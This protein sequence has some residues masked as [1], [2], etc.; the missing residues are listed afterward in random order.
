MPSSA[1]RRLLFVLIPL[2]LSAAPA[3]R[4]PAPRPAGLATH[5]GQQPAPTFRVAV[6]HVE[7]TARIVDGQGRFVDDL[8]QDELEILEENKPQSIS[9]F[10]LVDIPVEPAVPRPP[11]LAA[12][13]PDV[14]TNTA[15]SDGR[16]YVLVLDNLNVAPD[17]I[18]EVRRIARRFL[19]KYFADGDVAA[20][21]NTMGTADAS[22]EFTTNRQRLL[23]AVERLAPFVSRLEGLGNLDLVPGGRSALAN[24]TLLSLKTMTERL[25]TVHGRRKAIVYFSEGPRFVADPSGES[26]LSES[27]A[28]LQS[29]REDKL[30][31]D[32]VDETAPLPLGAVRAAYQRL[33]AAAN[34]GNVAIY[35]VDPRGLGGAGISADGVAIES[36]SLN[37]R[38]LSDSTGGFATTDTNQL[39]AGFERIRQ[40]NSRYYVLGYYPSEAGRVGAFRKISVR[41]RRP[42]LRAIARNGYRV[43][44][45]AAASTS[46]N[47][48]ENAVTDALADAMDSLVPVSGLRL[49]ATATAFRG[50]K[51]GGDVIVSMQLDGRDLTL[52]CTE[53]NCR[54]S[55]EMVMGTMNSRAEKG[56]SAHEYVQLPFEDNAR[57][58]VVG[59]GIRLVRTLALAPGRFQLRVGVLDRPT[60]RVG[61][62]HIDVTVPDHDKTRLGMSGVLVT[63]SLAGRVPTTGGGPV[64]QLK[65]ELPGPP[66]LT[67]EFGA[68]ESLTLYAELYGS[69]AS[70]PGVIVATSVLD[71]NGREVYR[72]D[73]PP[74]EGAA[75]A[76]PPAPGK[77]EVR[78][79]VP[80]KELAPGQY[81]LRLEARVPP[82]TEGPV[83]QSVPFRVVQ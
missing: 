74:T 1:F 50:A 2:A 43:P 9:D 48:K 22:Q 16:V 17:R 60:Q 45:K 61:V 34:R 56:P 7:V 36:G 32:N 54:A 41:V 82:G 65:R 6:N 5:D 77:V 37:L 20:V 25:S 13:E 67:R 46:R 75:A 62:V 47:E 69:A 26:S 29:G 35:A 63:S 64:A 73:G 15:G 79:T 81:L 59:S 30:T 21:V 28:S 44:P 39:D 83:G 58:L 71:E 76:E 53:G 10:A 72:H 31:P 12:A 33:V 4:P 70:A 57:P 3:A 49:S 8:R 40:E 51:P 27:D 24:D 80:L 23:S 42:G 11:A 14:Q 38:A 55:L 78:R 19:E 18:P 52:S 68:N 66:A